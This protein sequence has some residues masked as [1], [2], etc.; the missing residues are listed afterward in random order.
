MK[1]ILFPTDFSEAA[2]SALNIAINLAKEVDAELFILH[3]LNSVQQYVDISLSTAGDITMPGMQPDV[4]MAAIDQ[5]KKRVDQKMNDLVEKVKSFDVKVQSE[6]VH[7]ALEYEINDVAFKY[8]IDFI[9]MGTHGASGL[10]ETF[11]GSVAQKIVRVAKVPVL[12]V[13]GT[14]D[15]FAINKVVCCSDFTEDQIN[16]Q[17]PRVKAFTDIFNAEFDLVYINTPTYFEESKTV[18]TRMNDVSEKF[19]LSPSSINIYNS[20]DIDEGVIAFAEQQNANVI[21]MITHGYRGMKKLFSDNITQSVVNHS[22]VP[23][24]TLHIH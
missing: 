9:I 7:P 20:F 17:L 4:V 19:D 2:E 15:N 18:M 16:E 6:V 22:K 11:I 10:R 1:R 14:G 3:S 21:A 13:N 24:L 5:E 12:T 8:S 23:V